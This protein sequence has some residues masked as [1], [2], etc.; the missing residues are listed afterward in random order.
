M[1]RRTALELEQAIGTA[2][3]ERVHMVV[4]FPVFDAA[5]AVVGIGGVSSDITQRKATEQALLEQRTLL[6][7]SQS[8]ARVGSWEWEPATGRL[9]WSEEMY[10]IY[11]VS[12]AEF[13]PSFEA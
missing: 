5:G 7:E 11:G 4:K 9:A 8:L 12:R 3:G 6:S 10:R 1:E 13:Q 2:E